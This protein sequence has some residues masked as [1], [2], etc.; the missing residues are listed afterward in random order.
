MQ[1]ESGPVRLNSQTV[2][3]PPELQPAVDDTLRRWET[4]K[5]IEKLWAGDAELWTGKDENKWVGWLQIADNQLANADRFAQLAKEIKSAG[6]SHAL[7]LGMGGSSLCPEVL[8]LTFGQVDGYPELHVLDSTDPAQ[9]RT[10]EQQIDL[11]RTLFIVSS[12]SGGTLEPNIFK[13]YF[14]DRT[15]QSVGDDTGQRFMAITDPGSK[16][17]KVAEADKFRHVLFGLPS[18][19]GRYSALSDFGMAPAAVMGI[20]VETFLRRAQEM[21]AACSTSHLGSDNPGLVLGATL[22]TLAGAPFKRD[23]V[24]II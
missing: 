11:S 3:L 7:L 21:V 16:M 6:F 4:N 17:Q 20:D 1:K 5:L 19:G 8:R 10:R 15:R 24:T 12:K 22:G 14:F 18:I 9:V 2:V 13:Q 23:K